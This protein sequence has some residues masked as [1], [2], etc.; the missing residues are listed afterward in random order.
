MNSKTRSPGFRKPISM[1]SLANI[2]EF[3]TAYRHTIA[4]VGAI[5]TL[6]RPAALW[7]NRTMLRQTGDEGA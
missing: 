3:F 6:S 4:A 5:G 7:H 1:A 2:E